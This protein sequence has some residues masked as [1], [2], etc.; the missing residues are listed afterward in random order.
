MFGH[1]VAGARMEYRVALKGRTTTEGQAWQPWEL[2]HPPKRTADG[3][4]PKRFDFGTT[5]EDRD[6]EGNAA[7]R[8]VPYEYFRVPMVRVP[9]EDGKLRDL[10]AGDLLSIAVVA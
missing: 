10:Q 9:G 5:V 8:N 3:L 1:G 2:E 4:W 7:T 6:D